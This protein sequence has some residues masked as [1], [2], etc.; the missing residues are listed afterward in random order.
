ML[1]LFFN[2]IVLKITK[3][4]LDLVI[5]FKAGLGVWGGGK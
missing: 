1:L 3:A 4:I 2:H 5:K